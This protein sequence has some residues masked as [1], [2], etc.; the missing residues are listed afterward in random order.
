MSLDL[1]E[2]ESN[3]EMG[4]MD[5]EGSAAG[6]GV[7][8]RRKRKQEDYD[9]EDDFID[10]TELAWEEK[11]LMAKDGFFVYSG[12]LIAADEKPTIE[13]FVITLE[14]FPASTNTT[15][16]RWNSQTW[17]WAWKG[18]QYPR[19]DFW[20]RQRT[21]RRSWIAGRQYSPQAP[22]DQS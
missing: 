13:R 1:S 6:N 20:S 14:I 3:V 17:A 21:W 7:K 2:P 18:W 11:A 8:K 9:K 15:Q 22:R 4:G 19:R 10:D 16:S 5:D 12:P